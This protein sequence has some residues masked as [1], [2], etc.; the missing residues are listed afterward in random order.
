[1]AVGVEQ[2][3]L[4]IVR[5]ILAAIAGA[6]GGGNE[7]ANRIHAGLYPAKAPLY[8]QVQVGE[9]R[10][11]LNGDK[12]LV[13]ALHGGK[14]ARESSAAAAGELARVIGV[15]ADK[16]Q[17]QLAAVRS[18][19][20]WYLA[21]SP[22]E[23]SQR[24]FFAA[25]FGAKSDIAGL[26]SGQL[27]GRV[28][29]ISDTYAGRKLH[30]LKLSRRLSVWFTE[31]DGLAAFGNDPLAVKRFILQCRKQKPQLRR[32]KDKAVLHLQSDGEAFWN[33]LLPL[34]PDHDR[35]EVFL[36]TPF[37]DPA[38]FESFQAR[39]TAT[40]LE[41]TFKI[42][43]GSDAV[44]L[45]AAPAKASVLSQY[46]PKSGGQG[47]VLMPKD[48]AAIYRTVM[49]RLAA[50]FPNDNDV[51]FFEQAL[52]RELGLDLKKDVMPQLKAGGIV[53]LAPLADNDLDDRVIL[54]FEGKDAAKARQTFAK[55]EAA[56]AARQNGVSSEAIKGGRYA[57]SGRN[58][59]VKLGI[60]NGVVAVTG[61]RK[62]TAKEF[63][64]V[65][66][67]KADAKLAAGQKGTIAAGVLDLSGTFP[68]R[69][70]PIRASLKWAEKDLMLTSDVKL[71]DFLV[72]MLS[73]KK[74]P[75]LL[76]FQAKSIMVHNA[77]NLKQIGLGCL[78]YSG[79]HRGVFPPNL[80]TLAD[81]GILDEGAVY[82]YRDPGTG[83]RKLRY[84]YCPG[85]RDDHAQPTTTMIAADP[86][87][88]DGKRCALFVDGHVELLP[89]TRFQK[90]AKRQG[91]KPGGG[92][93]KKEIPKAR[94]GEIRKLCEQLGSTKFKVRAA[95]KKKLKAL[96]AQAHPILK[97]YTEH[98]DPEIR[99]VV[100]E[101]LGE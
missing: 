74:K 39:L 69:Q 1:M 93:T 3:W 56:V 63:I 34:V 40:G 99:M 6:G 75:R 94:Q 31:H 61:A 64:A 95:A 58:G 62:V 12:D 55:M 37:F 78:M 80:K 35:D 16:L 8:A 20:V 72:P 25:D 54:L 77:G 9:L 89:E 19:G 97:E 5:L 53:S 32:N 49:K 86:K 15:P 51:R 2:S 98:K 23:E 48:P 71:K 4:M 96:G 79:E 92:V 50:A 30:E 100:K 22:E 60:A 68:G 42:A 28:R 91:W 21:F 47:F 43:A 24:L 67:T 85:F 70:K 7:T 27:K 45:L 73:G 82:K 76:P 87:P 18:I 14:S 29:L 10:Q 17:A 83:E 26:L 52:G 41:G 59:R 57:E 36:V 38:A 66:E 65:L 84:I 33:S 46:L 11:F 88:F 81:E 44:K 13:K 101:L 90:L